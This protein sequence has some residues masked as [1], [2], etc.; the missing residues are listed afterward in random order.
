MLALALAPFAGLAGTA[1]A[2][3]GAELYL[4]HCAACH[5]A[6]RLGGTGPALLPESLHRLRGEKLA[7][8]I[9]EGRAATQ[10][11]G[12]AEVLS[13]AEIAAIAGYVKAAPADAPVWGAK[14]I[15]AS[16][17]LRLAPEALVEAPV[18]EASLS[19]SG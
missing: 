3:P 9:A 1:A 14:E 4:K 11:P 16:R 2:D 17:V 19:V 13:E 10:M 18:F 6:D 7:K 5:G 12:F 8:V 15:E